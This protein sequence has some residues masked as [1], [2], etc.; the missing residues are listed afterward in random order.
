MT[1]MTANSREGPR[2]IFGAGEMADHVI[3]Q[4]QSMGIPTGLIE[5][6]DDNY[7]GRRSGPADLPVIG[8]MQDGVDRLKL[9]PEPSLI[10]IGTRGAGFRWKLYRQLV[11]AGV[12]LVSTVDETATIAPS[13]SFG[14]N[15]IVQANATLAKNARLA[16]LCFVSIGAILEH[17]A[18]VGDNVFV[19]PGAVMAGHVT[20]ERHAFIGVGA[21]LAPGVTIGERALIG[22]GAV[23][24]GNIPAGMVAMGVP[25]R[26]VRAV[27]SGMDAPTADEV[28]SPA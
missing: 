14:Q 1:L 9:A 20:I 19:G 18:V 3:R 12:P 2:F 4:L 25:A 15:T 6:F 11:G 7:P 5:L 10:A 26:T 17:D 8:T 21:V 27:T 16:D 28:S 23:V 13:A 22:A 24:V